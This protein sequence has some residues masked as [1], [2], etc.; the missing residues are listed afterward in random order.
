VGLVLDTSALVALE[1]LTDGFETALGALGAES[2]VIPAIVYAELLVGVRLADGAARAAARKARVDALI[3]RFPVVDFTREIAERWAD[4]FA[5]LSRAGTMIP[6]NDLAIAATAL[7]L[8]FGV[9]VGPKDERHYRQV[10]N[11]RCERFPA[12]QPP[13]R[14]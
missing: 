7:A 11:L 1:R 13:R 3:S 5:T 12:R 9:L 14:R 4:L 8:D 6:S 2:A 10:P